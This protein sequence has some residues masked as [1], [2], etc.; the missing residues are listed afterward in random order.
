MAL[1][2][3]TEAKVSLKKVRPIVLKT[4]NVA[5]ELMSI[6]KSYDIRVESLDFAILDV[7]TLTR[8]GNESKDEGWEEISRNEV[9]ELDTTKTLL[10]P[11]FQIKQI[12]EVEI[13]SKNLEEDLFKNFHA[14][15][16]ANATK[17]KVYLSIKEGSVLTYHQ[18]FEKDLLIFVNKHKMRA[19]ILIDIFDEMLSDTISKIS[20][21]VRVQETITYTKNETI[22]IAQSFEPTP[23]IDDEIIYH[24]NKKE[25]V[26]ANDKIDYASRDFI[27][28]VLKDELIIEYIKIKEGKPGRNCR[29]EFMLP[30]EPLI[31]NIPTFKLDQS[32]KQIDTPHSI[33][34]RAAINGYIVYAADTYSVQKELDVGEIS[35]KTTGSINSGLDSEVFINVKETN[36]M[37]D[38]VGTSMNIEVSEI[39]VDGNTGPNSNIHAN[40]ATIGGQTHKTSTI[41]ADELKINTHR[42]IAYGKNISIKIL[43][44]GIVEG[45]RVELEQ[46]IGGDVKAREIIVDICG[47]YLKATAS[48]LIEIKQLHGSE[49]V[50]TIDPSVKIGAQE[51]EGVNDS[52]I[53]ELE[54]SIKDI[55]AEVSKYTTIIEDN[56]PTFNSVKKKL[57]HY[58]KNGVTMPTSFIRQYNLFKKTEEHLTNIK[59]ELEQKKE[60]LLELTNKVFS[61]QDDIFDARVINRDQWVG[62]NEIRFKLINPPME[63]IFKPQQAS[64]DKVFGLVKLESGEFVIQAVKE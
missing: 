22:L 8:Q 29:G 3:S 35:F 38:A 9:Y 43:E 6:A 48:K 64:T 63:L 33:E 30:K 47:S 31:T 37:K 27:H 26:D 10:N 40:K 62:Y 11:N 54:T 25:Q 5:K 14:A 15:V 60:N 57:L 46:V 52:T 24:Y 51:G 16:G 41:R 1:F 55:T 42:G 34:Y 21:H 36:F 56:L 61:L 19:G 49:N 53:K 45:D 4:Q 59:N 17:C 50:F 58:K 13:F 2:D 18:N 23:T 32:I 7:Q 28:S 20:A 39:E 12:Y 44:H